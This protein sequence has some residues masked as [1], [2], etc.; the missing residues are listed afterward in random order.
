MDFSK[1]DEYFCPPTVYVW[2]SDCNTWPSEVK[3]IIANMMFDLGMDKMHELVE[4][5]TAIQARDW[6]TAAGEMTRSQ[7]SQQD[8]DRAARLIHM[9]QNVASGVDSQEAFEADLHRVLKVIYYLRRD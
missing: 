7:W 6:T 8:N 1:R 2:S 4:F 9:M 5:K 3:E